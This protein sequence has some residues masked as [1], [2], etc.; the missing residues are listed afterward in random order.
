MKMQKV[1]VNTGE[2][3]DHYPIDVVNSKYG[4]IIR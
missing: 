1:V 3:L 4:I 2:H